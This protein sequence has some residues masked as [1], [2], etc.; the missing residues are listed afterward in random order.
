MKDEFKNSNAYATHAHLLLSN[1]TAADTT[2]LHELSSA[3][4][5][6]FQTDPSFQKQ[7]SKKT[8]NLLRHQAQQ[9]LLNV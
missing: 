8:K 7:P 3:S 9:Q 4:L 5:T 6:H 2:C 1:P